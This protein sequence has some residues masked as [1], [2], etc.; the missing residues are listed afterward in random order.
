MPLCL[1]DAKRLVRGRGTAAPSGVGVESFVSLTQL[2]AR[3]GHLGSLDLLKMDIEGSEFSVITSLSDEIAPRQIV[4]ETHVHNAY[5]QVGR[6]RS[7]REWTWLWSKLWALGYGTFAMEN[8]HY[9]SCCCEFSV[10]RGVPIAHGP[11]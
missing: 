9:C 4:F 3:L 5:G 10:Q 8:N 1:G 6:P 11:A 2:Q 7:G